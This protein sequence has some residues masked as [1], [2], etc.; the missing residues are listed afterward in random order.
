MTNIAF[1][2]Y[3]SLGLITNNF[4]RTMLRVAMSRIRKIVSEGKISERDILIKVLNDMNFSENYI[5]EVLESYDE[6]KKNISI[7]NAEKIY[8]ALN[9]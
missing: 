4:T 3:A 1:Y 5:N 8:L 7:K 9:I 2:G 6:F